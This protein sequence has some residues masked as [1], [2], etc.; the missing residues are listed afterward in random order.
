MIL[1]LQVNNHN[2]L[3]SESLSED[4]SDEKVTINVG[5]INPFHSNLKLQEMNYK[6]VYAHAC[7]HYNF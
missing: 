6:V 7:P 3:R 4:D 5:Q 2:E 1:G